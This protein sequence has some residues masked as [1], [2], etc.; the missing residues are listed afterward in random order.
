[1][2][3]LFPRLVS[4]WFYQPTPVKLEFRELVEPLGITNFSGF[5]ILVNFCSC[6]AALRVARNRAIPGHQVWNA[7]VRVAR[8]SQSPLMKPRW[9]WRGLRSK[10][11]KAISS[12]Q[13]SREQI[14]T[15]KPASP[16][17]PNLSNRIFASSLGF[18]I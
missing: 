12:P 13:I 10:L 5:F 8:D 16:K 11:A 4:S 9:W 7:V 3:Y 6:S 18:H 17:K 2:K 14:T 1:M 15:K